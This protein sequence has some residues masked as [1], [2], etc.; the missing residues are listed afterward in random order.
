MHL[1]SSGVF[2]YL[3]SN[4]TARLL[5]ALQ[6]SSALEAKLKKSSAPWNPISFLQAVQYLQYLGISLVKG[7]LW[8]NELSTTTLR[9]QPSIGKPGLGNHIGLGNWD[10]YWKIR[11]DCSLEHLWL[12]TH[13]I[14]IIKPTP[15][16]NPF[17]HYYDS[18]HCNQKG[19]L[20]QRL[21]HELTVSACCG[22]EPF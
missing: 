5:R 1:K 10:L 17:L 22:L 21:Y 14:S 4:A 15:V 9:G 16:F 12:R 18:F 2:V 19:Q 20:L 13:F 6:Q 8:W 7:L 3:P 11:Q